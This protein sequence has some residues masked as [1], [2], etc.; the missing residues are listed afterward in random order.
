MHGPARSSLGANP[1]LFCSL[2]LLFPLLYKRKIFKAFFSLFAKATMMMVVIL[3]SSSIGVADVLHVLMIC[4]LVGC[5]F[6]FCTVGKTWAYFQ[7]LQFVQDG[8][9]IIGRHLLVSMLTRFF[10]TNLCLYSK[11]QSTIERCRKSDNCL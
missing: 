4:F 6:A 10:F 2:I 11:W 1:V 8:R 3:V 7:R 9:L 5:D